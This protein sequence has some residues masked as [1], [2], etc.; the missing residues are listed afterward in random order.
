ML[1]RGFDVVPTDGS[2]EMA[3]EAERFLQRP[4]R[5]MQFA[6]LDDSDAFDGVWASASLLHVPRGELTGILARVRRALRPD[7]RF[8]ASF[9][10]GTEAGRDALGRFYNYLDE[11][12]LHRHYEAAGS[13]ARLATTAMA[14]SGYDGKPTDWLWVDAQK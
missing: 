14:G 11:A 7:G 1:A 9:K 13:W 5:V 10:A 4:V 12:E 6:D 2:P 8:W 3:A